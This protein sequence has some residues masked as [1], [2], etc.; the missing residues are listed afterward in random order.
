MKKIEQTYE[1]I[2]NDLIEKITGMEIL[3]GDALDSENV[4]AEKY[5][6]SRGTI[7]KAFADLES[8]GYLLQT[9]RG[10]NRIVASRAEQIAVANKQKKIMLLIPSKKDFFI[11]IIDEA[12]RRCELLGWTMCLRHNSDERA[13]Q[14][15]IAEI[16]DGGYDGALIMPYCP[17]LGMNVMTFQRLAKEKIPFVLLCKP[18]RNF[19]CNAVYVDDYI[20]SMDITKR[21]RKRRCREIVHITDSF[22][23]CIVRRDRLEGYY[24]AIAAVGQKETKIFDFRVPGVKKE[25]E[26]YLL[27]TANKIG[28]NLYNNALFGQIKDVLDRCNKKYGIDYEAEG[29]Y[30]EETPR[31]WNI[32]PVYIPQERIIARAL[33]IL[34][35]CFFGENSDYVTHDVFNVRPSKRN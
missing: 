35:T 18:V 29:F 30:E 28:F 20:A 27:Q 3:P 31:E 34:S 33:S 32:S 4:T 12:A 24:D 16:V 5:G 21:L 19:L 25:F 2:V 23:N 11:P 1:Q 17:Q 6:V 10:K 8:R 14:D 7:R 9:S 26:Y 15:A 13:E 22:M